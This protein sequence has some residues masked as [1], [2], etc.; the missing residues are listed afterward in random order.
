MNPKQLLSRSARSALSGGPRRA[1][2]RFGGPAP[3][4]GYA[5][6]RRQFLGSAAGAAG[7]ALGWMPGLARA[8][9]PGD[10]VPIPGGFTAGGV[11]FHVFAPGAPGLDPV[12]A[13]PATITDF[14]GFVGLAFINSTVTEINTKT[15][16]RRQL[17]S[18]GSDMRFMQGVFRD[19]QG[20]VRQ[21]TFALV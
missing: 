8:G 7:L 9:G 2:P 17:P 15:G 18:N 21:G 5:L 14:H 12:D 10:P 1:A 6:S 20:R 13:D 19:T 4:G 11:L 16:E 3:V